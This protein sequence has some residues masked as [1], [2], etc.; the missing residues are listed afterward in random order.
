MKYRFRDFPITQKFMSVLILAMGTGVALA[1]LISQGS[2]L[3]SRADSALEEARAMAQIIGTNSAAPLV[4]GDRGA[5]DR[6]LESLRGTREVLS[7]S[8]TDSEG[9]LVAGYGQAR[10]ADAAYGGLDGGPLD[11][12]AAALRSKAIAVEHAV[13]LDREQVGTL[14][15][16]VDL[17]PLRSE[18]IQQSWITAL[19]MLFAFLAALLIA[20]KLSH[21]VTG[22]MFELVDT[23]RR[24]S[25]ER[26]FS[27]RARRHGDDELG[28]LTDAF[29]ELLHEI[30]IRETEI[31]AHQSTLEQKVEERTDAVRRQAEELRL[32]KEQLALALDGSSLAIWDWDIAGGEVYLSSH[33]GEIIGGEAVESRTTSHGLMSRLHPDDAGTVDRNARAVLAGHVPNF[34]VEHRIRDV[35]GDWRWMR[36]TGKVVTR[37]NAGKALRMTGTTGDISQHKQVE[38][39]LRAAKESA[40]SANV[41]KS[42]FLANM[43]HE[44][45]TPMNGILGM[46]ELLLQSGLNDNQRH[47][48]KTVERSAD[49]L[50]QIIN[51]ILDFS[52]IEAG[53]MDLEHVEFDLT[54]S[55]EDVVQIFGERASSKGIEL[56]CSVDGETPTRLRGDP[57]RLR[58]V[59]TNLINNAVKF[60][61]KGEVVVRARAERREGSFVVLRF[62]VR[63]TGIGIAP[64][65]QR[66]IFD[67]FAQADGSTTRHFGGTGLGLS[68]VQQLVRLMGG[69]IHVESAQGAGSMFWFTVRLEVA[70]TTQATE[71]AS[72][73]MKNL[74]VLVVDDNATN[75]EIFEHQL[76]I[77]GVEPVSAPDGATALRVLDA[78]GSL[79]DVVILDM[80]MPGMSG[81]DVATAIR[82]RFR[83][84]QA[85]KIVVL[86][87][88]GYSVNAEM[89]SGLGVS[90]WLRKPVRQSELHR[91]LAATRGVVLDETVLDA[92]LPPIASC[93]LKGRVLLVEDNIV[94]QLVA[95]EMLS[96]LG[97]RIEVA[98]NGREAL[99]ALSNSRFDAV[100]M[101]CQMPELDG[102]QATRAIREREQVAGGARLP[103]IALTAN[104]LEGDRERCIEAGMDDYLT[105]PF[106]REQLARVLSRHL[107]AGSAPRASAPAL[108]RADD[109]TTIDESMLDNIRALAPGE[110]L[111]RQVLAAYLES[112]PKLLSELSNALASAETDR[113]HRAAHTLKSSSANVGAFRL[114]EICREVEAQVRDGELGAPREALARIHSEYERAAAALRAIAEKVQA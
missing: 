103:V 96:G 46:T 7:A 91:C 77:V 62:E 85:P 89:L 114:S 42:Q 70:P 99:E 43:S 36:S 61:A 9:R 3:A 79:F 11:L 31:R 56:A 68:I 52:K 104:A 59:L 107:P 76:R 33:W 16:I 25:R 88:V 101:D 57:L 32:A 10:A 110:T 21:A 20:G 55:I 111:L 58:Q 102:Y 45:R 22:P 105:K 53:R 54:E 41:A 95:R 4:F 63:D 40:E 65:A 97:C 19:G 2:V 106:K 23:V 47:L 15:L 26:R 74:R 37:D 71:P 100:L 108:P 28:V 39:A 34:S 112:S 87:S 67:A 44:I 13:M 66:R 6:I 69:E 50:L 78:P 75:R 18:F 83:D 8:L 17:A 30:E 1:Y 38:T 24:V 98:G 64:E 92:T 90:T 60:T 5:A 80:Q 94:N 14:R 48:A 81:L 12:I 72:A 73:A 51:D 86:S 84:R 93:R 49:H 27:L 109:N 29:N 35:N 82:E 113:A